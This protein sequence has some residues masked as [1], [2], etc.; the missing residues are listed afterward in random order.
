MI[1]IAA[2]LPS[3][4]WLLTRITRITLT[5]LGLLFHLIPTPED[6]SRQVRGLCL[7]HI[8]V[9]IILLS[10]ERYVFSIGRGFSGP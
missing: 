10:K 3:M 5:V 9:H 7:R 6:A 1:H 4:L 8:Q 2:Q